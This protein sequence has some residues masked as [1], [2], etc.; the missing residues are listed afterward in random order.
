MLLLLVEGRGSREGEF[1]CAFEGV[2]ESVRARAVF[3]GEC[4]L[5][6]GIGIAC[7][8]VHTSDFKQDG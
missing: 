2:G 8:T 5:L 3:G 1:E 7:C 4:E 6:K